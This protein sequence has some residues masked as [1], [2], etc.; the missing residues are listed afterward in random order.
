MRDKTS[1]DDYQGRKQKRRRIGHTQPVGSIGPKPGK[2]IPSNTREVAPNQLG[3]ESEAMVTPP[4]IP[5]SSV[6]ASRE[7]V[8]TPATTASSNLQEVAPSPEGMRRAIVSKP[9]QSPNVPARQNGGSR[10]AKAAVD[11]STHH[12]EASLPTG[13]RMKQ[14]SILGMMMMS[15]PTSRDERSPASSVTRRKGKPSKEELKVMQRGRIQSKVSA[16]GPTAAKQQ[17]SEIRKWISA[18]RRSK[19]TKEEMDPGTPA[20]QPVGRFAASDQPTRTTDL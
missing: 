12:Q 13:C 5:E 7:I 6:P 14:Q 10:P 3:K 19:V 8:T 20:L 18:G 15:S 1:D 17:S 9:A 11:S 4:I 16:A 2:D